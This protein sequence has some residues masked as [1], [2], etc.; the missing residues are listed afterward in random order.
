MFRDPKFIYKN[1]LELLP[2]AQKKSIKKE[3]FLRLSVVALSFSLT[4]GILFLVSLLP[5]YFLSSVKKNS[6]SQGFENKKSAS[7]ALG[8]DLLVAVRNSKEMLALLK[9]ADGKF[10]MQDSIVKIISKKNSGVKIDGIS[11]NHSKNGQYRISLRGTSKNRE[12]LKS[13]A[14]SLRAEKEFNGVDLP[15]SNFTKISDIDFNIT[16]NT[17]I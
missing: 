17:A 12:L 15:I 5:S 13:F 6:V 2:N 14:E 9:P 8:E 3:Y 11:M 16:L 1:M 7:A 4:A 10:S